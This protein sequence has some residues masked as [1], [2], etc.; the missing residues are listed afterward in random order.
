[1]L[2]IYHRYNFLYTNHWLN[3]IQKDMNCT[4][5]KSLFLY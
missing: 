3:G 5:S 2:Q 1:V 4:H